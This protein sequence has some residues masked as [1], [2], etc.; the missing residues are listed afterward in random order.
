LQLARQRND[1]LYRYRKILHN[2]IA[3]LPPWQY[4]IQLDFMQDKSTVVRVD[5]MSV[6]KIDSVL[7]AD[8]LIAKNG[9]MSHLKLQKLLYYVQAWHL[10]ILDDSIVE[11]QFR[12]W[13]HGPVSTKVWHH[14]KSANSPVFNAVKIDP[15]AAK[16]ALGETRR[17]LK[18]EQLSLI[19][20]VETEYGKLNAYELEAQTHSEAPWLNAR[21]GTAPDESSNAIIT[22]E[23]MKKFY[24]Q[25]L[26]GKR[27]TTKTA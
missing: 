23:A 14:F 20:D 22:K 9:S 16:N 25:R 11:D 12:A 13:M 26:Y 21:A 17:I 24:R 7:L 8:Y 19:D 1:E 2:P 18:P 3:N 15:K 4:A 27:A 10:A 5:K 6:P